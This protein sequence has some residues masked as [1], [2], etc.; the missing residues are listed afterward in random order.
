MRRPVGLSFR[1]QLLI[2]HDL[3]RTDRFPHC[4]D[5]RSRPCGLTAIGV[6]G[7]I[8][9]SGKLPQAIG[10]RQRLVSNQLAIES[11]ANSLGLL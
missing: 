8:V 7:G 10:S 11:W 4:L 5:R 6:S 2:F 9:A 3:T 1:S